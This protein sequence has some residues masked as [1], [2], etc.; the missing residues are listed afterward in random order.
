MKIKRL[1]IIGF[2]SFVDRVSLDFPQGIT[3][4]VGPNGCGKSNIVD[5]I[6]WVMGEQSARNLRGKSMED[7]IFGG[8]ESRKPLGMAEVSLVFSAE[9]GRVPAKY[10]NY[11][12]IQ[13]TRRLYR[14][15]ES[16]YLL[17]KTPCRL[18]DIAELFMD[19]GVGARAYSI[20]E[21]GRIGMILLS[22]PEERR[23][24]IEEAAGVTKFKARKQVALKKIEL[25]RQNLLRIGDIIAELKRQLNSL[26]RQAKKAERFREYREELKEIEVASAVTNFI[27]LDGDMERVASELAELDGRSATL[28]GE[29]ENGELALEEQ[30]IA[31]LEE[32][33]AL[34]I[35]Q[36]EL[37][38]GKGEIQA[39]EN[40]LEF[41]RKEFL[42]LDRLKGRLSEELAN[43]Q[44]QLGEAEA[45]LK[46]LE[47][48]RGLFV[49][50]MAGEEEALSSGEK[51]LEE[52]T[53]AE[54]DL[55]GRLD[56]TR[57]ELFALLSE[58][59]QLHNQQTGATRRLEAISERFQRNHRERVTFQEKLAEAASRGAELR[60]ALQ[61][62]TGEKG[63]VVEAL[64]ACRGR[65]E[66][67]K[68]ALEVAERELV[69]LRDELSTKGSRL[70]SLQELEAQFAGY[71]QGVRS[72]FL[73]EL[74]R[75]RFSGV[76]A[77]AVE[78]DEQYEAALEAVLGERLQYVICPADEDALAAVAYLKETG[79]GRCSLVPAGLALP[80]ANQSPAGVEKL[81]GKV[82][83][84]EGCHGLMESLLADTCLAGDL[85]AALAL[86]RQYP[87]LT[88]VTL[89]GDLVSSGGIING[90]S[91]EGAQ[92][93]LVHK[94]REIKELALQ[95]AA[96]SAKVQEKET[97]RERLKG[98]ISAAGEELR[99]LRQ[100]L[101]E[102]EIRMVNCD[103]DLQRSVEDCRG[104][105]ERLAIKG[106]E[107]DQ[108]REEEDGLRKEI[109]LAGRKRSAGEE[110]KAGLEAETAGMQEALAVQK[111]QID[112]LREVVTGM[113]VRAAAL[114]EKRE[115]NIRT[116][117]RV[118]E[119]AG[120]LR[121]R[122]AAHLAEL[123]K[124][125]EDH[126]LLVTA[127]AGNEEQ[128]KHQ[129][130]R[131]LNAEASF[132]G[133]KERYEGKASVVQ[134][135][136]ARLRGVRAAGEEVRQAI[137]ERNFRR[138]ELAM[139][140]QNLESS[141]MERYR[142][143]IAQLVPEYRELTYD[144]TGRRTR[145]VE[146]QRLIDE[147]GEVNLT[148]IEEYR[149]LEERFTFLSAQKG[150]LEES[151][152]SLQKAIQRINRTTRKR[153]LETF[154]LVNA[155]FQEVFPRLFC[156]GRAELRLT[157]EEDLLE[158]GIEIIVQ[159]P[160]KKLQNV[161]L[162]SGGE[163]ALTAVALI[164]SIF[165]I[166]PSPFCL[167]DEVDAPLD[168][169]NIGRFNEMV[170]EMTAFSQFIMITHSKATMAVADTL[171]GVT[172]E[173]PGVSK[174]V[175]VRLN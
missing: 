64:A 87:C 29:L 8:C 125:A 163:K 158:T 24:L 21:Q 78:T 41:Q 137:A 83:V 66:G 73:A 119:L 74:F 6:R 99:S 162:L 102:T 103:K 91:G 147:M 17:N 96:V 131:Q 69:A 95:V 105:E 172:M 48:R 35:A 9:D 84:R 31:L 51:S 45:E 170:R 23:F 161:T 121:G 174:L 107:D 135:E 110:R 144:E 54:R 104:I 94:K 165:L 120:D 56:G 77:D 115:S 59:A 38:R 117:L 80:P 171:F 61:A 13:V 138:S 19:T 12:E 132:A 156:G 90:G 18:M 127:I 52:L 46:T 150:D 146:L 123:E 5:A 166:K 76:L 22:K 152:Q 112:E 65:E 26:Q 50:E 68:G 60:L 62:L 124:C 145:H 114:R 111:R 113:K 10:L 27:S 15:G 55:A 153:F 86:A 143:D 175:S 140:L 40:R 36:E 173:E 63:G 148:A 33:K 109:E 2:K 72:L 167:L 67:L 89:Q 151:L 136:E 157:N 155:K 70:H 93:G 4:V 130:Q 85:A 169:A 164:F 47:E 159:P 142:L 75:G 14:D 97:E 88:F 32:E 44:R 30:R 43:L 34:S 39:A 154:Q 108:L 149:E 100:Q 168:D 7:V 122:I 11:S 92:Q 20:I 58:I 28:L 118:E 3:A 128:L 42:N 81:L 25:S 71:G 134:E 141:L 160:G 49:S 82:T 37:Y 101:H 126:R 129:L 79:G 53:G 98:E 139:K 16:E 106:M 116:V 57:R 1:E 133:V